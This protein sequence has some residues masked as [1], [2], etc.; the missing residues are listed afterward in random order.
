[1]DKDILAKQLEHPNVQYIEANQHFNVYA[2][3]T[4]EQAGATWGITRISQRDLALTQ[5]YRYFAS[6]GAGVDAYVIDTGVLTTHAQF[7]SRAKFGANF[8]VGGPD[9][10]CNGHGTHVAGTIGGITYGV[11]KRVT[12]IGV[13]VLDCAGSGTYDA[14]I[15]GIEYVTKTH[16]SSTSKRSVSNM[17]LGGGASPTVDAAVTASVAGGVVHAIAAGNNNGNACS[18]SPARTPTA[19]T[20]GATTNTDAR[21]TYSNFGTCVDIFA[22]GTSITSAWI[23][24]NT[25]T[26]TISGT[27]MAT[28]HVAGA[29]ALHL[30]H[31]AT[32]N[33]AILTPAQIDAALKTIGTPGKVGTPGT[34]SP[35]LLLFAPFSE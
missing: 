18:Y 27:S 22:P 26:N 21:A 3:S 28:P 11:A 8:V 24:S 14:V 30:A 29:V 19:I 6:A 10:D 32:I 1:M 4:V 9:E 20:V 33:D 15:A 7:E 31:A 34:G 5:P 35:N 12:I 2:D 25:A 23:G 17:S 13:K 16:Q